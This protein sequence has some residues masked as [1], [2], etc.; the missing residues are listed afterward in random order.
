LGILEK[1]DYL[2]NTDKDVKIILKLILKNIKFDDMDC[3]LLA[4]GTGQW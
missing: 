4:Q 1:R 3:I 2:G